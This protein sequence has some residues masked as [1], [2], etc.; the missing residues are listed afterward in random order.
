[1]KI[2]NVDVFNSHYSKTQVTLTQ[3]TP[4]DFPQRTTHP[5]PLNV[6]DVQQVD[7]DV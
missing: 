7:V 6:E 1:M 3:L 4:L 5:P 2:I